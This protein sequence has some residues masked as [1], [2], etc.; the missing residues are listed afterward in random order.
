MSREGFAKKETFEQRPRGGREGGPVDRRLFRAKGTATA[1]ILR[2]EGICM[3][4]EQHRSR[5]Q[6][7]DVGRW[8]AVGR[9]VRSMGAGA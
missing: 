1:K 5:W 2:K 9:E 6:Q 4:Q 3:R 8:R 7:R